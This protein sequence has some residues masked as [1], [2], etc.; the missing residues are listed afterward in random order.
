RPQAPKELPQTAPA[1]TDDYLKI[2]SYG[3]GSDHFS[4]AGPGIY[5]FNWWF[6]D[7][8]RLHLNALTWPDAPKDT[9]MSLG[10]H[11]NSSA[12]LPS[13]GLAIVCAEGD[14]GEVKGGDRGS[15]M[16]RILAKLAESATGSTGSPEQPGSL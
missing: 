14:W 12:I 10:A 16:N 1:E 8:G 4:S 2:E 13:L 6:N 5:G 3:G 7:T 15:K 9:V 11:G